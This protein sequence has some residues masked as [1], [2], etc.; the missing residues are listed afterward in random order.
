MLLRMVLRGFRGVV[1]RMGVVAMRY[2]G[3]VAGFL[4]IAFL[5]MFG[6]LTMVFGSLVKMLGGLGVVMGSFL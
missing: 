3:V 4:V 6:G 5:M 2:V 1:R